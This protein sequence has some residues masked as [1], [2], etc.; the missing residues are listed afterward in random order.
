MISDKAAGV[1]QK[2]TGYSQNTLSNSLHS[3][4]LGEHNMLVIDRTRA[5]LSDAAA[6]VLIVI[7]VPVILVMLSYY[8]IGF[9]ISELDNLDPMP[10]NQAILLGVAFAIMC[11]LA[12]IRT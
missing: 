11:S 7:S 5:K 9:L 6:W 3:N 8:A 1:S 12:F 2:D 10:R 4:D